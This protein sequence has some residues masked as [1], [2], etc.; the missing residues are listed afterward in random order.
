MESVIDFY[1]SACLAFCLKL[2]YLFR[3]RG[4]RV[5]RVPRVA[6]VRNRLSSDQFGGSGQRLAVV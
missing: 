3:D 5:P 2:A 4:R 6:G 1:D